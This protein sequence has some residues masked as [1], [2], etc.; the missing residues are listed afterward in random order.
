MHDTADGGHL[1]GGAMDCMITDGVDETGTSKRQSRQP[2]L[3]LARLM[4]LVALAVG[5]ACSSEPSASDD[6]S[7]PPRLDLGPDAVMGAETGTA[8]EAGLLSDA[9]AADCDTKAQACASQFGS[10]FTKSN[11]RADGKL[12]AVVRP[13]DSQCALNNST[14]VVL[15][16]SILGQVQRLVVAVKDVAVTSV[17]SPLV[18]PVYSEGWHTNVHLDYPKDLGVHSDVF[19]PVSMDKAVSFICSPLDIGA[20]VSVY[21]YS[22][23]SHPSSAHQIHRNDKYPDGAIVMDP[24]ATKPTYLLFRYANQV[25]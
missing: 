10:L 3:G 17:A 16:L 14:H 2:R 18:G 15:Q 21:A 12:V 9:K 5:A 11:G 6:A 25:F 23:G 13:S 8:V 1:P 19:T 24:K 22:D 7:G 4:A 20:P